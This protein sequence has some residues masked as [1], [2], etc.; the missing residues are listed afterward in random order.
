MCE[1]RCGS[2]DFKSLGTIDLGTRPL[3]IAMCKKCSAYQGLI[4]GHC[5]SVIAEN[6][7]TGLALE[8]FNRFNEEMRM[9]LSEINN[10]GLEEAERTKLIE[11]LW[12]MENYNGA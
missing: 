5:F 4:D 8:E 2:N 11:F 1:N 6:L 7:V 3:H 12:K 9:P 10:R